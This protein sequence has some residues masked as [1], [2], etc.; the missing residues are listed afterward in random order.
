VFVGQT[1]GSVKSNVV[2]FLA[3]GVSILFHR[4]LAMVWW[5][6]RD[7]WKQSKEERKSM[8]KSSALASEKN[9]CGIAAKSSYCC[10]D[11]QA[12]TYIDKSTSNNA[13][14]ARE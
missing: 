3:A 1:N 2:L 7:G 12:A 6:S 8:G 5:A 13:V 4:D 14:I 11:H 9:G 10:S